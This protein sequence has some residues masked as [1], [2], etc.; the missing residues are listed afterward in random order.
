MTYPTTIPDA[1]K[2]HEDLEDAYR[3]GW[4]H[5]H[6][7]AC[8]NVPTIGDRISPEVDWQGLGKRVNESNIRDYH[9]LLCHAG[10]DNSRQYSPFEF[11]AHEFNEHPS[12]PEEGDDTPTSEEMWEAFEA[13]T[14]DAISADLSAYTNADYGIR[15]DPPNPFCDDD[16]DGNDDHI[17]ALKEALGE[18]LAMVR[19]LREAYGPLHDT[20]SDLIEDGTATLDNA[21]RATLADQLEKCVR[22]DGEAMVLLTSIP[23]DA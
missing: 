10:A 21:A 17:D 2:T 14:A 19:S 15:N 3:R 6:G 5:G 11:T 12:E 23:E 8:H 4:S 9:S 20:L 13:G 16:W 7:I 22:V 18:A 1:Y